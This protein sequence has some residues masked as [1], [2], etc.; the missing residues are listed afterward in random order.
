[1]LEC[2]LIVVGL[3]MNI[4][5]IGQY[6]GSMIRSIE[7]RKMGVI[8]LIVAIFE[9]V[10]M[11]VGNMLTRIP[12]FRNSSSDE[13]KK[14]CYFV[15]GLLFLL[16]ASYM[17]YKAFRSEQIQ[18]R[19]REIGYK[20]IILEVLIVALFTFLAGIGWGFIGNNIF[21]ATFVVI[22]STRAAVLFGFFVGYKEGCIFR[23]GIYGI[24]GVMLASV[25][26]E[27]LVRYI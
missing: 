8:C 7:W 22:A 16:I 23:H 10:P 3:A 13:L 17:L 12:F 15:A 27:I 26:I 18:E 20:R 11:L 21:V 9:S 6:E 2:T 14:F 5:L 1:M 19:L 4:F 25:G 24:G